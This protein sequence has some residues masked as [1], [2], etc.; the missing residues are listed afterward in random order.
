MRCISDVL[1][2]VKEMP[3]KAVLGDLDWK[4]FFIA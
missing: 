1:K 3:F 2:K 4:I